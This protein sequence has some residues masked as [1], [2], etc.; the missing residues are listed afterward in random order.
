MATYSC[1]Y[2]S[3]NNK[4][5]TPLVTTAP[6]H[7]DVI[8]G[9]VIPTTPAI[10]RQ[11]LLWQRKEFICKK[12]IYDCNYNSSDS[13]ATTFM[14]SYSCTY[15]SSDSKATTFVATYSCTYNS[16]DNKVTTPLVPTAPTH[17]DVIGG[18]LYLQL[19]R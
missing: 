15:N 17:Q 18:P 11:R 19:Q 8:G 10:A 16:S 4:V 13:K 3:S 5:T 14:A 1:T 12:E 9:S 7:Q 6:T 2:N